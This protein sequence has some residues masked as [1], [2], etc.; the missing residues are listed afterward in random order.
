MAW[1]KSWVV[2]HVFFFHIFSRIPN[3]PPNFPSV[4]PHGPPVFPIFLPV[5]PQFPSVFSV[6]A[7]GIRQVMVGDLSLLGQAPGCPGKHGEIRP[8]LRPVS[9]GYPP[10]L[11]ENHRKTT[12]KPQNG[13]FIRENPIKIWKVAVGK[14]MVYDGL[15]ERE[16]PNR[17]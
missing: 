12:G 3:C 4:F 13:W 6:W 9:R 7:G 15:F 1:P 11:W 10:N 2:L 8:R 17:K 16:N 5:F 14:W